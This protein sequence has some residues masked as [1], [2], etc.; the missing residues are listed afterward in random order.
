MF[1]KIFISL[2]V[3]SNLLFSKS[4]FNIVLNDVK[5][6]KITKDRLIYIIEAKSKNQNNKNLKKFLF[7][8]K[9]KIISSSFYY[10]DGSFKTKDL[11]L[12]FEKAYFLEGNFIIINLEGK[13]KK[14]YF[15]AKKA[16]YSINKIL[17]NR[18][19]LIDG[20]MKYRKINHTIPLI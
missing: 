13:H 12:K 17:L 11:E 2:F 20:K 7:F 19:Y 9:E 8:N 15:K 10:L 14:S 18:V 4:N 1:L 6:Y 3:F 16:T 5:E